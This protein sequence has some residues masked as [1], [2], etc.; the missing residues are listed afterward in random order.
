MFK[1]T[2]SLSSVISSLERA[3]ALAQ[4]N[5]D[6]SRRQTPSKT[7]FTENFEGAS[8]TTQ[9]DEIEQYRLQMEQCTQRIGNTLKTLDNISLSSNQVL[10]E[11]ESNQTRYI[12]DQ[13]QRAEV[14]L[15]IEY[16]TRNLNF[17]RINREIIE[18][19]EKIDYNAK[20]WKRSLNDL[21]LKPKIPKGGTKSELKED[22]LEY[23]REDATLASMLEFSPD[24]IISSELSKQKCHSFAEKSLHKV[25]R[26]IEKEKEN[27]LEEIRNLNKEIHEKE[28]DASML[29]NQ[30]EN[31][32]STLKDQLNNVNKI[33]D[34]T[35]QIIGC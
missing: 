5:N 23:T 18:V 22:E 20:N 26:T 30:L 4:Q 24:Q 16:H 33:K 25:Q 28:N 8:L 21:G 6:S 9:V 12:K 29:K 1:V 3:N 2:S 35:H 7:T 31:I 27:I 10:G 34:G 19:D 17:K 14:A 15:P 11:H 32:E 13:I